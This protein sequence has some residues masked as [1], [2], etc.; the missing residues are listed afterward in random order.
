MTPTRKIS[1]SAIAGALTVLLVWALSG[2]DITVPAEV[3][4]AITLLISFAVG[5]LVPERPTD[6][7]EPNIP[8]GSIL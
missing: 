7:T 1:A 8:P 5:Y 3:A 4:A 6:P 2:L